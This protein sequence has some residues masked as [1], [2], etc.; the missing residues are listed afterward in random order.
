MPFKGV[1]ICIY[2]QVFN[3]YLSRA[4]G[5]QTSRGENSGPDVLKI[6]KGTYTFTTNF[7]TDTDK[8]LLN[9]EIESI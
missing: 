5:S 1:A 9:L 7:F 8:A 2:V 6:A 4:R 3:L